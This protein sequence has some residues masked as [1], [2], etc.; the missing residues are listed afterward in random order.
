MD[1]NLPPYMT[2]GTT[3]VVVGAG[4]VYV[5][6]APKKVGDQEVSAA[7]YLEAGS[8]GRVTYVKRTDILIDFEG[9]VLTVDPSCFGSLLPEHDHPWW[10]HYRFE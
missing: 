5:G 4:Y 10:S 1:I 6:H 9:L 2:V 3:V 7:C 8:K